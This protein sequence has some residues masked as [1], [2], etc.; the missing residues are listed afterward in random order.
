MHRVSMPYRYRHH[1][2]RLASS[3]ELP[4]LEC[5]RLPEQTAWDVSIAYGSLA[6]NG[7]DASDQRPGLRVVNG[8][9]VFSYSNLGQFLVTA[10]REVVADLLPEADP[11]LVRSCLLTAVTPML[12]HQ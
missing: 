6:P 9:A 11:A 8:S 1:G 10:G 4:E 3:I 12:C 7:D 2:L 5:R